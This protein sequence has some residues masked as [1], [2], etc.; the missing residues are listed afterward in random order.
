[1]FHFKDKV[2]IVT[3]AAGNLGMAVAQAFKDAG[4]CLVLVDRKAERLSRLYPDLASDQGHL[5]AGSVDATDPASVQDMA[6]E[7]VRRFGRVDVL[8]NAVGGYEAGK[9]V[10]ETS[11]E[12]WDGMFSLNARTAFVASQAVIPHMLRQGSGKIINIAA[13]SGLVGKA[14]MAAYSASKAAV[15]RL[16]ESLSAELR[17]SGVNVN[18][19]VPG[20][21]DTPENRD[22]MPEADAG[23]WVAPGS[24]ADVILFLASDAARDVHG[25]I[26]PV[27][28]RS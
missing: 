10:H 13:R 18:C 11:L 3:G 1:M 25:A 6:Q 2:I 14:N 19:V 16:S 9:P 5:L 20:T 8:V 22:A 24:L 17:D 26:L 23:R 28:G 7:A 4:A 27:I 21:I 15:I 12:A